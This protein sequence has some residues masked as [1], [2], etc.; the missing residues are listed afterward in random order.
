[1]EPTFI[2]DN[3]MTRFDGAGMSINIANVSISGGVTNEN[4]NAGEIM[5]VQLRAM[6]PG[7]FDT[8]TSTKYTEMAYV[9][10]L[11]IPELERCSFGAMVDHPIM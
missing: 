7:T 8:D 2:E 3:V 5:T 1:M 10:F 9:R 4:E 6:I 11:A